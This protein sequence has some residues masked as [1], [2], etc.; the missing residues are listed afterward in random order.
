[1]IRLAGVSKSFPTGGRLVPVLHEIQLEIGPGEMVALV[2]SSGSGK[3]TLMNILGGLDRPTSGQYFLDRQEIG[4]LDT[5]ALARVR[6]VYIGFVFQS[7]NLVPTLTA[8]ENVELPLVYRGVAPAERRRRSTEVLERIGLG[9]HQRLKPFQLSGGQQQRVAI[10]RALVGNPR[11]LLADEPTGNL[12][13]G[14]SA[15]VLDL[16]QAIHQSGGHTMVL[17]THDRAVARACQRT[18]E[19]ADG[20]I[21]QEVL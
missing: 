19:I 16:F 3:T 1:M 10:C 2:G 7:F 17:V 21:A 4:R 6:N 12:D 14:T 15:E 11:V 5:R 20:H 9:A 8:L 18:V 13:S